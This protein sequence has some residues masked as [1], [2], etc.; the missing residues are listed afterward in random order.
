ME[1]CMGD[2]TSGAGSTAELVLARARRGDLQALE[3]LFRAHEGAVFNLARRLCRRPEDA[4]E[5]LQET[6]LEVSRSLSRF[7]GD[8]PLSAWI[9]RIAA[10]KAFA[11]MRHE[12]IRRSESL[13][14]AGDDDPRLGAADAA[15]VTG[16]MD[17]ET[18]LGRLPAPSRAVVWLHDVEGYTHEEIGELMQRSASF[19]KSQLARAHRR[20]RRWLGG[21]AATGRQA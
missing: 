18:A 2:T 6:F 14:E 15:D 3:T 4:E 1:H 7:R 12:G 10:N 9:R 21:D 17:L 8:G 16:R 13:A 5:V 19:S 20:L 11:R